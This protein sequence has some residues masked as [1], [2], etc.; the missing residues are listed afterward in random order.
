M[1]LHDTLVAAW[2]GYPQ[3]YRP[4]QG[5]QGYQ[6]PYPP[7]QGPPQPINI[8][9]QAPPPQGY[10]QV[11]YAPGYPPPGY[12]P[13]YPQAPYYPPPQPYGAPLSHPCSLLLATQQRPRNLHGCCIAWK[14]MGL[15]SDCLLCLCMCCAIDNYQRLVGCRLPCRVPAGTAGRLPAGALP[16]PPFQRRRGP[17]GDGR[18]RARRGAAGGCAGAP[19]G[20]RLWR[21]C[22]RL[23]LLQFLSAE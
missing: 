5:Y 3:Y 12:P 14:R 11:G 15:S 20:R 2:Q 17:A 19:V 16:P 13:A 18:G 21:R 10:Q 1:A 7:Q 8:N 23:G 6:Q 22:A 4:N 9:I